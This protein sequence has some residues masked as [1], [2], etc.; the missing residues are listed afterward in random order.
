MN[1][2]LESNLVFWLFVGP[3]VLAFTLVVLVPFGLGLWYS[4]T[5]WSSSA[6]AG[7]STQ[8]IGLLNYEKSF[9]DP[10]FSFSFLITFIY[11]D[12]KSVV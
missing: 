7:A 6:R 8:F 9:L 5:T 3:V 10:A 2:K 1:K 4:F 11:T 12:R